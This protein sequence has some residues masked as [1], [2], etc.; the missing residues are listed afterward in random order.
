MM[1]VR[2]SSESGK[3]KQRMGLQDAAPLSL[4]L[5]K[6]TGLIWLLD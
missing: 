6:L 1:M 2:L 5:G 4:R 3:M